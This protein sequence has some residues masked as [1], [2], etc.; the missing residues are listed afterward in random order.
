MY[1]IVMYESR[2]SRHL[3]KNYIPTSVTLCV[4]C[5]LKIYLGV[6]IFSVLCHFISF[7]S[8]PG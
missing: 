1:E 4:L 8:L 2:M 6:Q 5:E 7:P 3:S